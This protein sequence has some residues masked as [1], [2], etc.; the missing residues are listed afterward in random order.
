M[1]DWTQSLGHQQHE[2]LHRLTK[3]S[4]RTHGNT[5]PGSEGGP[6]PHHSGS[7]AQQQG[8]QMQNTLLGFVN[9]VPGTGA[10]T[11]ALGVQPTRDGGDEGMGGPPAVGAGFYGNETTMQTQT[12]S[13]VAPGGGGGGAA[14]TQS[15]YSTTSMQTNS[16]G[17]PQGPPLSSYSPHPSSSYAPPAGP[18]PSFAPTHTHQQQHQYQPPNT[19]GY[20]PSYASPPPPSAHSPPIGMPDVMFPG[21]HGSHH[22][23]QGGFPTPPGGGYGQPQPH[24]S[25]GYAAPQGP[26]P[27]FPAPGGFPIPAREFP[28]A[29]ADTDTDV[30]PHLRQYNLHDLQQPIPPFP[31]SRPPY[32][33]GW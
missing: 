8:S 30:P 21:G 29:N 25:G 15:F 6:A 9:Q 11:S 12:A 14:V 16:Y 7:L 1:R 28:G 23:G 17:P 26:P 24:S 18:P 4:V 33:G 2:I 13:Y 3:N 10:L 5:R 27:G 22:S 19:S 31:G 32:K 20:A